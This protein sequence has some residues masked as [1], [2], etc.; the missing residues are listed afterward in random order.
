MPADPEVRARRLEAI[1][2]LL[3]TEPIHAQSDLAERLRAHGFE[4]TQSSVSRDLNDLGV[5]KMQGRYLIPPAGTAAAAAP[6]D[7]LA[8]L[9]RATV[10]RVNTAGPYLVVVHT[11][12]GAASAVGLAIDQAGWPEVEGT[13][14]GDDTIFVAVAGKRH[15]N[16]LVKR[17]AAIAPALQAGRSAK[18][19]RAPRTRARLPASKVPSHA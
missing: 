11:T 17:L 5:A 13:V 18:T 1:R 12:V 6:I 4:V 16:R 9:M 14:A 10:S 15:Q 8:Q 3:D 2:S 19:S 7:A